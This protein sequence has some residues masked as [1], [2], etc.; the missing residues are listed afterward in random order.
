M[1]ENT[2]PHEKLGANK[3]LLVDT[4]RVASTG[5]SCCYGLKRIYQRRPC[6]TLQ[7]QRRCQRSDRCTAEHCQ[8]L[9]LNAIATTVLVIR[10]GSSFNLEE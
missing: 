7:R 2:V 6:E 1:I 8:S 10:V 9:L 5:A 3:L 4:D